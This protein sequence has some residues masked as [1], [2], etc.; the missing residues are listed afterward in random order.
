M[1]NGLIGEALVGSELNSRADVGAIVSDA[2]L[3]TPRPML[4]A[5]F[6]QDL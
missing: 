6:R 2:A 3:L 1:S 4:V 5:T